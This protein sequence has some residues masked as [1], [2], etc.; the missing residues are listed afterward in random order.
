MGRHR[1]GLGFAKQC[2]RAPGGEGGGF[3]ARF[4]SPLAENRKSIEP[5]YRARALVREIERQPEPDC[6]VEPM[7]LNIITRRQPSPHKCAA[8]LERRG[9]V[10]SDAVCPPTDRQPP[11]AMSPESAA[12]ADG[13]GTDT[14][15]TR[16][17]PPHRRTCAGSGLRVF[18]MP[19]SCRASRRSSRAGVARAPANK[20]T[21]GGRPRPRRRATTLLPLG[22][23]FSAAVLTAVAALASRCGPAAGSVG[24][25]AGADSLRPECREALSAAEQAAQARGWWRSSEGSSG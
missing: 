5:G 21:G 15:P 11:G 18:E 7:A 3:A 1:G 24:E 9:V 19:G 4:C 22:S 23:G 8:A 13:S 10:I 17:R 16:E 14:H 12:Q 6:G 2:A 25:N 20:R